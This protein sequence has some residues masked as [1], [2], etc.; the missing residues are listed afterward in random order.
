MPGCATRNAN[1]TAW[2]NVIVSMR[3]LARE[4]PFHFAALP[5]LMLLV[6]L[7]PPLDWDGLFYHLACPR[8]DVEQVTNWGGCF[9]D[10]AT[11]ILSANPYN[12]EAE[13]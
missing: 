7:S 4:L 12:R 9:S 2:T 5:L 10:S 3:L 11:Q 1:R 8:L 6:T 13:G